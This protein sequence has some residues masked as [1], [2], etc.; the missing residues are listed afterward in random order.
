MINYLRRISLPL[1]IL[2]L[3]D[4]IAIVLLLILMFGFGTFDYVANL[5]NSWTYAT[6]DHLQFI[7]YTLYAT[8]FKIQFPLLL[9]MIGYIYSGNRLRAMLRVMSKVN[10]MLLFSIS[11]TFAL[12]FGYIS[13]YFS[14]NFV[15]YGYYFSFTTIST[16][17]F[18]FLGLLVG[19]QLT[20]F[21]NLKYR[22]IGLKAGI[23]ALSLAMT[24]AFSSLFKMV[25]LYSFDMNSFTVS[26][27]ENNLSHIG[28][29]ALPAY[30]IYLYLPLL[31]VL[32][33]SALLIYSFV[34]I[35]KVGQS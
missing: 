21:S 6:A 30:N 5:Q 11:A 26:R 34:F 18:V 12:I 24:Y 29:I 3:L 4:M 10:S 31:A 23:Y 22:N 33:V 14:Y 19:Y 8:S 17:W 16:V 7:L 28:Q 15:N 2:V 13:T 32:V 9:V 20:N 35:K 25:F 27:L 1:L